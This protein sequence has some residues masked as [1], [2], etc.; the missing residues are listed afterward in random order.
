MVADIPANTDAG[1]A[2]ATV[3]LAATVTDDRDTRLEPV[4]SLAADSAAL[5]VSYEASVGVTT[6]H[7]RAQDAAGNIG[8]TTFD[9]TV[10]DSELPVF[11]GVPDTVQALAGVGSTATASWTPPTATDN[12]GSVALTSTHMPGDSFPTGTTKVVYTATDPSG[13]IATAWFFVIVNPAEAVKNTGPSGPVTVGAS[14][15]YAVTITNPSPFVALDV[16]AAIALGNPTAPATPA[17]L[18]GAL[19]SVSGP[20]MAPGW[21]LFGPPGG[22]GVGGIAQGGDLGTGTSCTVTLTL[23]AAARTV[24]DTYPVFA[25]SIFETS[26]KNQFTGLF[27]NLLSIIVADVDLVAPVIAASNVAVNTDT[28][29]STASVPLAASV[30]DNLDTGL[31]LVF[32]LAMKGA[33]IKSPATFDPGVT[34][35]FVRAEDAAG[36][37][38]RAEFTVTVADAQMPTLTVAN[39]AVP[40]DAGVATALVAL[41]ATVADN[42]GEAL[43]PI[44]S[45]T[46]NSPAITSPASSG[47]GMTDVFVRAEA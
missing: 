18:A 21:T 31:T 16:F 28:G 23:T 24:E 13:V 42:S 35:V 6:I 26:P 15:S 19:G 1:E 3:S 41:T 17:G 36:N 14:V 8:R 40:S 46:L 44:F 43:E 33:A 2:F 29:V 4:F 25:I 20:C 10:T 30:A 37:I 38:G 45:L 11:A 34:R 47:I 22:S 32:S 27:T 39:V 7:A 5:P 12:S 9:M